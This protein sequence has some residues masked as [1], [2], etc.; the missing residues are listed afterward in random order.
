MLRFEDDY[1]LH[2]LHQITCIL[3][4]QLNT[5]TDSTCC[6]MS[7][8]KQLTLFDVHFVALDDV[9]EVNDSV[10]DIDIESEESINGQCNYLIRIITVLVIVF[11]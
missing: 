11:R 9:G 8:P 3:N 2:S 4:F 10:E 6:S 7:S 5:P 1:V